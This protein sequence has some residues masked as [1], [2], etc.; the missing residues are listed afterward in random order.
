MNKIKTSFLSRKC[1]ITTFLSQK[2]IYALIDSFLGF[3]GLIDSPTSYATL[4]ENTNKCD[5]NSREVAQNKRHTG[6]ATYKP[7]VI[8]L[9]PMPQS[10]RNKYFRVTVWM[11]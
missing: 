8:R 2:F 3:P 10:H 11:Y 1:A 5:L 9:R 7:T 4:V 6:R